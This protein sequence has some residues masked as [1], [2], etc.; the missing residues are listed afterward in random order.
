LLLLAFSAVSF[1]INNNTAF[2]FLVAF[3]FVFSANVLYS[4]LSF[5]STRKYIKEVNKSLSQ[6]K[7]GDV[8]SFPLPCVMGDKKGSSLLINSIN[9]IYD[10]KLPYE[11]RD[12]LLLK[13]HPENL[14]DFLLKEEN[15][16]PNDFQIVKCN[17]SNLDDLF[18]LQKNYDI[19]EVI[20]PGKEFNELNC[21]VTL[22]KILE[23]QII[24][25]IKNDSKFVAKAGSNAIGKNFIQLGGVFTDENYRGK[26][27]AKILIKELCKV[28]REEKKE[29]VLFVQVKN[30]S[31][32]RAYRQ[33]GFTYQSDYTICYYK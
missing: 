1:A 20:P 5:K 14:P 18:E 21:K 31:A 25:A 9:E 24:Y 15:T 6:D 11:N 10:G 3:I 22:K 27:F 32:K 33:V 19:V 30:E 8:D 12:Y 13:Y 26:G 4:V 2:I 23:S 28:I 29:P 16:L 7:I 17:E